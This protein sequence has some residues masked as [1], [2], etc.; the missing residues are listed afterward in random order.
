MKIKITLFFILVNLNFVH[1]QFCGTKQIE[2]E[3]SYL[4]SVTN[5]QYMD[6][7]TPICLNVFYHI[8]R[9]DNGV[10]TNAVFDS[11]L[12]G[13]VTE[14]LN[15]S[16]L[17]HNIYF[18]QQGFDYIDD[19]TYVEIHDW[20]S[21]TSE[22][23][24]LVQINNNPNA[25]NV[26]LVFNAFASWVARADGILSQ[27][28]VIENSYALSSNVMSHEIGHCLNLWHTFHGSAIEPASGLDPDACAEEISGINSD[29]CGD[30]V[31]DTPADAN[32]GATG[33]Y[34][35]D[36][37]NI[38]SYYQPFDHFTSGQADRVRQAIASSPTLQM[39]ISTSCSYVEPEISNLEYLCY[40][41]SETVFVNNIGDYTVNWQISP[42]LQLISFT[43]TSIT[44]EANNSFSSGIGWVE[45][46]FPGTSLVLREVFWIGKPSASG[47]KILS[48]GNFTIST[49][50]WYQ[51]SAHHQ[52]YNYNLHS[53]LNYE[54]QIP[55]AQL[56]TNPPQN[57]FLSV[58]PTQ[59]G[60]YPYKIRSKNSCGCSDWVTKY[61]GV[62]TS[63]VGGGR[64]ISP[65]D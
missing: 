64:H 19:S 52:N 9:G 39:T 59:V 3:P 40:P 14:D 11:N 22:F 17:G 5:S 8:I 48:S 43:N 12:L 41:S 44:F 29:S 15:N 42:N 33:G 45:A 58:Y 62:L 26:Y 61:F 38:M 13:D 28:I 25:I 35:P 63:P 65:A 30:Y 21:N 10:N 47:L 37:T 49:Q 20:G 23:G 51:L 60:T 6:S 16:F 32:I 24:E 55:Y 46:T 54:W 1:A 56:R 27:A 36:L 57:K 7:S 18:N 34:S 2:N 31:I 4:R 50:R 53:N